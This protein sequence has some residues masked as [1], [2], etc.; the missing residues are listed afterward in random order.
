KAIAGIGRLPSTVESRSIPIAL[1]RRMKTEAV[2]K[3]R[4]RDAFAEALDIRQ[5][6]ARLMP[7]AIEALRQAR[8][9]MP[10]GLSDLAEDVLEP[11]LAIA[12]QAGAEWP[13]AVR[14][15]AVMLM[16]DAAR[17]ARDVEQ[18]F[19]LELLADIQEIFVKLGNPAIVKTKVLI[20]ALVGLEDRPWA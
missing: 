6:L 2:R 10:Q 17:T 5:R 14:H 12:D 13:D 16:G 15:A 8:P 9:V 1:R 20:E 18:S 19:P 4:R 11:L 3:W 7:A